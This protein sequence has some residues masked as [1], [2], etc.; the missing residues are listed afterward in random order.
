VHGFA[1]LA[2]VA[3][4]MATHRIYKKTYFSTPST[5]AH[6]SYAFWAGEDWNRGR[7]K[8]EQQAFDISLANLR[9]GA[10]MPD[11]SWQH[12]LTIHDACQMGPEGRNLGVLVD[13]DELRREY[14]ED[15]FRNLFECEDVDDSESSFPW[16]LLKAAQVDSFYKWKDFRAAVIDVPGGRPFGEAPVWIGYDPNKQGRDDAALVVI[17]PPEQA[18]KG[19][20]RVLEKHRL[21]GLDFAGQADFIRKVA[22]RYNVVDIAIDVTNHGATVAELVSHWFPL[23]RKITYSVATKTAMVL[24][25]QNVFRNGRIEFDAGWIDIVQAFMA[26]RPGLTAS[27]RGVTYVT[28]RDGK[29]GHADVAWAILHALSNEPM[30]AGTGHEA[31]PVV[32]AFSD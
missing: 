7:K 19:K 21:N 30:E 16:A 22:G 6:Q 25:G 28:R 5:K 12:V 14:G 13:V 17:A 15:E 24:K 26:I 3:S 29:V 27:Q 20:F 23:V 2:K 18:G 1:Q 8:G 10:R 31:G 9:G 11:G 32:V 4:A